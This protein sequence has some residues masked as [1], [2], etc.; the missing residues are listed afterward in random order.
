MCWPAVPRAHLP[1]CEDCI[2]EFIEFE[3]F[4]AIS[5]LGPKEI[6]RGGIPALRDRLAPYR[7]DIAVDLRKHLDTRDVLLYTQARFLA[8]MTIWGSSR[9]WISRWNGKATGISRASAVMSQM[10]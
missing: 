1:K 7:F 2:D 4:H 9:S 10:I 6:S 5:G 8:A 3:F